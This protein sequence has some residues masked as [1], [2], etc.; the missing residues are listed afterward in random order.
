[1]ASE[2]FE[3]STPRDVSEITSSLKRKDSIAVVTFKLSR[4]H[5]VQEARGYESIIK[6][7]VSHLQVEECTTLAYDEFQN[8]CLTVNS[9]L[10][11]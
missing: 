3:G 5:V 8:S 6:V 9:N 4:V 7:Q 10:L 2:V 1:M 11:D